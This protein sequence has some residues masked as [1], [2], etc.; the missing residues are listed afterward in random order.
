MLAL[1]CLKLTLTVV[2]QPE[3]SCFLNRCS[4][5][6]FFFIVR[7]TKSDS[8]GTGTEVSDSNKS[9]KGIKVRPKH[10]AAPTILLCT[11]SVV[12]VHKAVWGSEE[13]ILLTHV[14]IKYN[15][16]PDN[17]FQCLYNFLMQE[18]LDTLNWDAERKVCDVENYT[19]K[20]H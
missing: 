20:K 12:I 5:V 14:S 17:V 11:T 9:V 1:E 13:N 16:L 3:L 19:L 2:H 18:F 6:C 8:G 15:I 10:L 4:F 7:N